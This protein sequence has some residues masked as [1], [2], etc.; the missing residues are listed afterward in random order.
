[1]KNFLILSIAFA[2]LCAHSNTPHI[3]VQNVDALS[4]LKAP[5][6]TCKSSKEYQNLT[7]QSKIN[8]IK[9]D[10][11]IDRLALDIANKYK[12]KT[13]FEFYLINA[14]KYNDSHISNNALNKKY[15][16]VC[17][18]AMLREIEGSFQESSNLLRKYL[19]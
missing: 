4:T 9:L 2:S 18:E 10:A 5:I 3:M 11:A 7:P 13:L 12:D 8:L 19:Q 16:A 6:T 17:S 1:M 15:G 14:K